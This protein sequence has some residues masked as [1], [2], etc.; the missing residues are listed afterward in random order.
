MH[1]FVKLDSC[2]VLLNGLPKNKIQRL[3]DVLN[4]AARLVTL[5]RKHDQISPVLME[6][7][8]LSVEQRVEFKILLF[9]Y[10]VVNGM[11]PVYLKDLLD[12]YRPCRSLRSGNMRLLKTQS[13]NLTTHRFRAFFIC[14]PQLWNALS[15]ELRACDS[16][17]SFKK[18]L[19]TFLFKEACCWVKLKQTFLW[20][21]VRDCSQDFE[22]YLRYILFFKVIFNFLWTWSACGLVRSY[23]LVMLAE[24]HE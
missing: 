6:F 16:L 22:I 18:S 11:A 15:R 2:N 14:A 9:T 8:W 13:Y 10:K 23:S 20:T 1:A 3:H 5:S 7:H 19:T 24:H 21:Y 17:G 12:L 4:S